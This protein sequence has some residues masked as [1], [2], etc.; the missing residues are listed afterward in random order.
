MKKK[1]FYFFGLSILIFVL[2][3]LFIYAAEL[4]SDDELHQQQFNMKYGIFAILQP[5]ALNFAGE[6]IPIQQTTAITEL[7][8]LDSSPEAIACNVATQRGGRS[9]VDHSERLDVGLILFPE[10]QTIPETANIWSVGIDFGT[11]NSCVY[12]KENKE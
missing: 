7:R 11:T 4:K 2:V 1:H 12:F 5:E 8:S 10:P 3:Q 6:E 9:F